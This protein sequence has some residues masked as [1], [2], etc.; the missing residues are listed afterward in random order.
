MLL[1]CNS[2]EDCKEYLEFLLCELKKE[3]VVLVLDDDVL[4]DIIV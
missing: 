4:N 3:E 2:V 1:F